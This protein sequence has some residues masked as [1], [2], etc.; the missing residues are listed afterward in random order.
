M[1]FCRLI[2]LLLIA[3]HISCAFQNESTRKIKVAA[4]LKSS[5]NPYFTLMWE[6]IRSESSRM[7]I[8]VDLY[9]PALESNVDYQY[10]ILSEKASQYDVLILSPSDIRGVVQYLPSIKKAGTSII[11]LDVGITVPDGADEK[12]YFDVLV[13]TDNEEGGLLAAEYAKKFL[14]N[15]S[16]V[17]ILGGF[18]QY[19]VIPGRITAFEQR[20]KELFPNINI[21]KFTADYEREK[22]VKVA[23]NNLSTFSNSDVLYCANDHMA[24]G[25]LDVF[26]HHNIKKRPHIIGY[27]SIL[28]AQQAIMEGRMDASVIQFPAQMGKE[29]VRDAVALR[30][31]EFVSRKIMIKP[32]L[33]VQRQ[34]IGSVKLGDIN[35]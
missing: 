20:I 21:T 26:G 30:R 17:V 24:L 9:W 4:L 32:E 2:L 13:G 18:P 27:D 16:N 31:G 8:D 10:K 11:V 14:N 19:M 33:S 34:Y 35:K 1:K 25:V 6:G 29:A 12:D 23:E 5:T 22:A 28:E 7:G 3:S 15:K